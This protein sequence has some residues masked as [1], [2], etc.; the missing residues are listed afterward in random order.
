MN[1]QSDIPEPIARALRNRQ[2]L[3]WVIQRYDLNVAAEPHDLDVSPAEARVRYRAEPD[4]TDQR[5]AALYWEAGWF[6]GAKSPLL[7]AMRRNAQEQPSNS[8]R[9]VVVLAGAADAKANVPSSEFLSAAVLP[10]LLDDSAPMDSR[11]GA[12]KPRVRERTAF[13]LSSRLSLF[14]GR[15]LVVLGA[16]TQADLSY[17]SEVLEDLPI[18]EMNVLLVWPGG[19]Q[20][21]EVPAMGTVKFSLWFGTADQFVER[22]RA[23]SIPGAGEIPAEGVRMG[24]RTITISAHELERIGSR[25][26]F[27]LERQLSPARTFTMENL[28]RFLAG[29]MNDWSAYTIGLPVGRDYKSGLG[30]TLRQEAASALEQLQR[31]DADILT[32]SIRVPAAGGSGVTTLLREVA[33]SAALD[34]YPTLVLRPNQVDIDAEDLLAFATSLNEAGLA[35]GL[36]DVPPLLLVADCEHESIRALKQLPQL[37]A[38]NGRKLV[39]LQAQGITE[40]ESGEARGKRVIRLAPLATAVS[41]EEVLNCHTTFE[42][43]AKQWNLPINVPSFDEWGAYE[44]SGRK[45]APSGVESYPTLFW[46]AL[47]FFLTH[48]VELSLGDDIH[49]QLGKWIE[50]RTAMIADSRM[51]EIVNY[52]AILSSFRMVAPMW[53]VIRPVTGGVFSSSLVSLLSNLSDM[54]TWGDFS[55]ELADQTVWFVH[56]AIAEE[57][58]RRKGVRDN[59]SKVEMLAPMLVAMSSG[60]PG[61]LWVAETIASTVLV[62][63]FEERRMAIDWDWRLRGFEQIPPAICEQSKAVLHHWA[64]CLYLSAENNAFQ[65]LPATERKARIELAIGKLEKAIALP[66]RQGRDEHPSHLYNTLGTALARYARLLETEEPDLRGAGEAWNKARIA[67]R[68]SINLLGGANMEALLAFTKYLLNRGSGSGSDQ[69]RGSLPERADEIAEALSLIDQAYDLLEDYANPD[70]SW[71]D[72]LSDYYALAIEWLKSGSGFE[73]VRSLQSDPIQHSDLGYYCEARLQLDQPTTDVGIKRA[74]EALERATAAGVSLQARSLNFQIWLLRR[75]S[76]LRFKYDGLREAYEEL[77]RVSRIQLPPIDQFRHAVLCYQTNDFIVGAERFRKLRETLRRTAV[78]IPR[79]R[80][81]WRDPRD[82]SVTRITQVRVTRVLS[83]FR[84]EGFVD[85][86]RQSVPLR[87][88]QFRPPAKEGSVVSCAIRFEVNGPLAVPAQFEPTAHKLAKQ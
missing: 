87:P 20:P 56:P 42:R 41:D 64:R 67:F 32:I 45:I 37:F 29:D 65:P 26:A 70:P 80:E 11:F 21:P 12:V 55:A 2:G 49:D 51:S 52:T 58:L 48:D 31:K 62:P 1:K 79:I 68:N 69:S 43:I 14:G 82:P 44:R 34:G 13:D 54:V 61:D 39:L 10:G 17:L 15:V 73:Y 66:S 22:L 50:K 16:K 57:F 53:T 19:V 35:S 28:H 63:A 81:T 77:E 30:K 27:I 72:E 85:E 40:T 60:H 8:R 6:E 24:K 78:A 25:F 9:A 71:H 75:H 36:D 59:S 86:L 84:G 5:L 7:E 4:Q 23:E 3:L 46:V 74:L 38:V 76:K 47:R 33:F 18:R 83:E 88:R